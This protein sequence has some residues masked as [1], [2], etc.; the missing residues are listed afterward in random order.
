MMNP[1]G[2]GVWGRVLLLAA[3]S[4]GA[5]FWPGS[6]VVLGAQESSALGRS[7]EVDWAASRVTL[8]LSAALEGS[9]ALIP[10]QRFRALT[11]IEN[12]LRSEWVAALGALRLDQSRTL[13]EVLAGEPGLLPQ[14]A[15][16]ARDL[17]QEYA[18]LSS[19]GRT[20]RVRYSQSLYPGL[21]RLFVRHQEPAEPDRLLRPIATRAYSG[22]VIYAPA[23]LRVLGAGEGSLVPALHPRFYDLAGRARHGIDFMEPEAALTRGL[24]VYA[25]GF[26]E[27]PYRERIGADP[28]R[29]VARGLFGQTPTDLVLADEDWDRLF[30]HPANRR[31]LREGRILIL[32]P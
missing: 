10:E 9:G 3:L 16:L 32:L 13:A 30:A 1:V 4:W 17:T 29:L 25:R 15:D 26:D 31:L 28:L 20:L 18:Q 5:G 23:R 6:R 24:A 7:F 22:L 14:L 2:P 21:A 12:S 19:D 11:R 8:T 27:S